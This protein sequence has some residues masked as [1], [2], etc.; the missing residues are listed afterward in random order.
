MK[1]K[2][3]KATR[4]E[5]EVAR[6]TPEPVLVVGPVSVEVL[7]G[8]VVTLNPLHSKHV[9]KIH[10]SRPKKVSQSEIKI[11]IIFFWL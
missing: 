9:Y 6:D 11:S 3:V 4:T 7:T 2:K 1:R 10:S 5:P 8:D